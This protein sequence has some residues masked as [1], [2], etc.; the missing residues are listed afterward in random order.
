MGEGGPAVSTPYR[1]RP[2]LTHWHC[3]AGKLRHR[4]S[5]ESLPSPAYLDVGH[6]TSC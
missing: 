1:P 6:G 2:V 3:L 4:G 5:T